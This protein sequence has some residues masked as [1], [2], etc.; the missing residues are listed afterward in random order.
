MI[1]VE[2]TLKLNHMNNVIGAMGLAGAGQ[3]I[4]LGIGSISLVRV[5]YII[6]REKVPWLRKD[7]DSTPTAESPAV[8]HKYMG[9]LGLTMANTNSIY[10]PSPPQR[11]SN[12]PGKRSSANLESVSNLPPL[13]A[14][15][16]H[17]KRSLPHRILLAWLPWL[18]LFEWSRHSM[19][20]SFDS[21][22]IFSNRNK[23]DSGVGFESTRVTQKPAQRERNRGSTTT[24]SPSTALLGS[25]PQLAPG[26]RGLMAATDDIEMLSRRSV[27]NSSD[28]GMY[29]GNGYDDRDEP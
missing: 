16:A 6:L 18:G 26:Q 7:E 5:S 21:Y 17:R 24:E 14:I 23:R 27:G 2:F 20:P 9:G 3:L 28:I 29:D 10:S 4:P 13:P 22:S 15:G 12:S 8:A 1:T 11:H 19:T 25:S